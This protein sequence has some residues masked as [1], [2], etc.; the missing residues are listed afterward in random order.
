MKTTSHRT[1]KD[2]ARVAVKR[3]RRHFANRTVGPTE[4]CPRPRQQRHDIST[5]VRH[6]TRA[7]SASASS[8]NPGGRIFLSPK[9]AWFTIR[10]FFG[11]VGFPP[12]DSPH[13][14]PDLYITN[15]DVW[16]AQSILREALTASRRLGWARVA[17]ETLVNPPQSVTSAA[18]SAAYH[19]IQELIRRRDGLKVY[20]T[21]VKTIRYNW[22]ETWAERLAGV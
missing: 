21:V 6:S 4:A 2:A 10:F 15:W 20:N 22:A 13:P 3:V 11:K 1:A 18:I 7:K 16:F 14:N 8:L 9:D 17:F 19:T 5:R 12:P